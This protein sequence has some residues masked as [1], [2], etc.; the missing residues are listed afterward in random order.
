MKPDGS[1][2]ITPLLAD[3]AHQ[4]PTQA[5]VDFAWV[6]DVRH[7]G[8]RVATRLV[9]EVEFCVA[10]IVYLCFSADKFGDLFGIEL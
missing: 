4:M 8:G 6:T 7:K 3:S 2:G 1:P 10:R 5:K 9:D